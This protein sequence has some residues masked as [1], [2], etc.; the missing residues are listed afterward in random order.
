[1]R[2][3]FSKCLL[4]LTTVRWYLTNSIKGRIPTPSSFFFIVQMY[5]TTD[6]TTVRMLQRNHACPLILREV[7]TEIYLIE[8]VAWITL[9]K[10]REPLIFLI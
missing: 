7:L 9:W 5:R 3:T 10:L 8:L 6:A 1:M 4:R 2:G